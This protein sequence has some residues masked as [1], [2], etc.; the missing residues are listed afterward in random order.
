MRVSTGPVIK[1]NQLLKIIKMK[2]CPKCGGELFMAPSNLLSASYYLPPNI[3]VPYCNKCGV[4]DR[5]LT[6][7]SFE[8]VLSSVTRFSDAKFG[9]DV[10]Y[11]VPLRHLKM[12]A[13]EAIESG[14]VEEFADC[15]ILILDA[16]RRRYP[17]GTTNLLLSAAFQKI[18]KNWHRK[19]VKDE[20]TGTFQHIEEYEI[21]YV[22]PADRYNT[23][24]WPIDPVLKKLTCFIAIILS[25]LF[26]FSQFAETVYLKKVDTAHITWISRDA[27]VDTIYPLWVRVKT[28]FGVKTLHHIKYFTLQY[29]KG[30]YR[31]CF[32]NGQPFHMVEFRVPEFDGIIQPKNEQYTRKK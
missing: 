19:W 23:G 15:L 29:H 11:T 16:F 2:N 28:N 17:A 8:N 5:S 21:P 10:H 26:C 14:S 31:F 32:P 24:S 27:L 13:D 6:N 7:T 12:E 3:A 30:Y 20:A 25:S 1:N 22:P 18:E 9:S 4:I